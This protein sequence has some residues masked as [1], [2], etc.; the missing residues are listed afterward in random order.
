[1]IPDF[2]ENGNLPAGFHKPTLMEFKSRFV[3][4][5]DVSKTRKDIFEGYK[6]YCGDLL[7]LN[8]A[9]KQWIDGSFTTNK[10]D[11]NDIDI[12]A[13][14]DALK[15]NSVQVLDKVARL[16]KDR[17]YLKSKYKCDPYSIA[18]YPPNHQL[19]KA[20]RDGIDYWQNW[21]GKDRDKNPK[22]I[23]EFELDDG[24]FSF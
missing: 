10:I 9:M 20:T 6:T 14:I 5:F 1:M 22:G 3:E 17:S 7:Q 19:Y 8:V 12:V 15:I 18:I 16:F 11:P 21:F 13:H 24:A 23:I 2:N 4:E